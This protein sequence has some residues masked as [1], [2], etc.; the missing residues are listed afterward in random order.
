VVV[1]AV[2]GV[3]K[4]QVREEGAKGDFDGKRRKKR[5][6]SVPA[7]SNGKRGKGQ[8]E[9]RTTYATANTFFALSCPTT[10]SSNPFFS[11]FRRNLVPK[12]A[13]A[14]RHYT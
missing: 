4:V 9:G 13:V 3:K 7:I 11:C 1:D 6:A 14:P 10:K 5:W 8:R 2:N 12:S